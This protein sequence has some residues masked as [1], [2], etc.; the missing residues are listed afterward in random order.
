MGV[1]VPKYMWAK[2]VKRLDGN[3]CVFCGSTDKLEAHHIMQRATN[4]EDE[5]DLEN[6]ITLCHRCHYTAHDSNYTTNGL[7]GPRYQKMTTDPET[8]QE[9][10]RQYYERTVVLEL[11]RGQLEE[12]AIA[13][14]AAG[15][16]VNAYIGQAI[17]ERIEREANEKQTDKQ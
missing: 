17:N 4:P 5:T 8:M 14:A 13:A 3:K 6:G 10:I 11:P 15:Q 7:H 9:F 16:S 1:K 2:E 12:I